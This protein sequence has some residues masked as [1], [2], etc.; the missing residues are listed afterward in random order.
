MLN[1]RRFIQLSASAES[2]MLG[3]A[4]LEACGGSA[5]AGSPAA[6]ASSPVEKPS[7]AASASAK[8][9]ASASAKP[10][11]SAS[12]KPAASAA[13]SA[14]PSAVAGGG[15][16]KVGFLSS[17]TGPQSPPG[18]SLYNGFELYVT[19]NGMKLG[20]RAI[21][22]VKADEASDPKPGLEQAKK[23]IEQD[24]VDV[25]AGVVLSPTMYAI[26]D[27]LA[28]APRKVM[29]VDANA[30][31]DGLDTTQKSDYVV[32]VSFSNTQANIPFGPY[33][34][35][36]MG[37]QSAVVAGPDYAAGHEKAEA[38]K[39]SFTQAGGKIVGEVYPPLGNTDYAPYISKMQQTKADTLYV[40][41][42]GS[43][44]LRFVQTSAQFG[45]KNSFKKIVGV[46][47][48][49][50]DSVL[51]AEGQAAA[52]LA[53]ITVAQWSDGLDTPENKKYVADY[54]AKYNKRADMFSEQGYNAGLLL[55][56]ALQKTGGDTGPAK[57]LQ[58]ML[59]AKWTA[60]RGPV[61]ISPEYHDIVQ[62]IYV[63]ETKMV[64]G[65]LMNQVI[66]TFENVPPVFPK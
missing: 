22:I 60:P 46:T 30:G 8:P 61:S 42:A 45:L 25:M 11:A 20:G 51:E 7:A 16:L 38:F 6:T 56:V 44:A 52:T 1:R 18:Q 29:V 64:N 2:L 48:F 35:K 59:G 24:K 34:F 37:L 10:A 58:A 31:A 9:A 36:D 63:S 14:K 49:V 43:D 3:S 17:F 12:T 21:E 5:P 15:T 4:L 27:Y 41:F 19:A 40:F 33:V 47:D 53:P 23:L 62:N 66:H 55:D 54:K 65:E 57:L 32:R 13:A 26:R 50:D 39:K 28:T